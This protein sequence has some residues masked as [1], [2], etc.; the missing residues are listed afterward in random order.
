MDSDPR[1][2]NFNVK[3]S[4]KRETYTIQQKSLFD[5]ATIRREA[6]DPKNYCFSNI[7]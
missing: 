4:E 3:N 2:S 5:C 7:D 6:W 1:F